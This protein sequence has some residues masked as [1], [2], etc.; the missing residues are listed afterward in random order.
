[1]SRLAAREPVDLAVRGRRSLSDLLWVA[2]TRHGPG[3]HWFARPAADA[4]D[5]DHLSSAAAAV[6]YLADHAVDLPAAT[7]TSRHLAELA[8][9]SDVV[10]GL[11]SSSGDPSGALGMLLSKAHFVLDAEGQLGADGAGWDAFI[12][13]LLLPLTEL[14]RSRRR[15]AMCGNDACRLVFLDDSKS[16]TRRWC[17][18]AGCGNRARLDRHRSRRRP[19]ELSQPAASPATA[20]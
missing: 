2:N 8:A 13:D 5:H 4:G 16:H 10:R 15:L 12:A 19:T 20:G 9:I 1:M 11:P 14:V 7:P 6:R 3:A 17:D 18:G